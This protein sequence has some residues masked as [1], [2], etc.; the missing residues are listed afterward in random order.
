MVLTLFLSFRYEAFLFVVAVSFV[1]VAAPSWHLFAQ[2]LI[3]V[4]WRSEEKTIVYVKS[5]EL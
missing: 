3:G 2:D 4:V 5:H 1:V